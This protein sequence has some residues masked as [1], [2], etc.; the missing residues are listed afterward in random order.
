MQKV[1]VW[2]FIFSIICILLFTEAAFSGSIDYSII[3]LDPFDFLLYLALAAFVLAVLGFGGI[4]NWKGL[5]RSIASLVITVGLSGVL[6]YIVF[7]GKL[8][9]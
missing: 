8:L 3:G 7:I 1:N 4:Q 9:S 5:A 6:A 2:S